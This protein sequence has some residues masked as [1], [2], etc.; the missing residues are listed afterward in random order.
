MKDFWPVSLRGRMIILTLLA[1]MIPMIV[2]GYIMKTDA[3][4]ALL[5][6]KQHKLFGAAMLLEQNIGDSF[7]EILIHQGMMQAD[8]STKLAMLN[9]ALAD[10]TDGVAT[11]YPGMGVGYYVYTQELEGIVTYGPSSLYAGKVG[12]LIG[13]NHPGMKVMQTGESRVEVGP[14]VRGNIMNAMVPIVRSSQVIGYVWANELTDNI[15]AQIAEMER[16]VFWSIGIG[17]LLSITLILWFADTIVSDVNSIKDGLTR[18]KQ[19]L[20]RF[21]AGP[22]GEIGEIADAINSMAQSLMEARTLTENIMDSMTDGIITVDNQELITSMNQAAEI[23]TGYEAAEIVGEPYEA[24]FCEGKQFH[25]LLLNTLRT[26]ESHLGQETDYPVRTGTIRISTSTTRL[27]DSDGKVIGAVVV[28]RDITDKYRLE[29]QVKRA[30][31]LAALGELMAGVAHEVRNPLTSI[32]GFVQYLA[33][34]DSEAERREYTPIIISEVDRVNRIIE[35][36][37]YFARPNVAAI[38]S[39]DVN[40]LLNQTLLLVKNKTTK[41]KVKFVLEFTPHLPMV[42]LDAE[43]FKQVFLNLLINAIQAINEQGRITITTARDDEA[44]QVVISFADTGIGI[45]EQESV[46]IF[47]PFYTTKETGTGLGLA[48]VHRIV[49]AHG[50]QI[51]VNSKLDQGTIITIAVP[52]QRSGGE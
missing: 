41:S 36:L 24:I 27:R 47:D 23:L 15:Q 30:D 37:L 39:V 52:F 1:V 16:N 46:K 9:A 13:E 26:G 18:M 33:D 49:T 29:Q 43:Q 3:E 42:E 4:E 31:R 25:S 19:D 6:E 11:A 35:E 22:T 2:A 50:G 45:C 10:Y 17:M 40:E 7:D 44:R 28:F 5:I 20:R 32:K 38:T 12:V 8:R 34:A 21:I 14:L 51:S 48:V